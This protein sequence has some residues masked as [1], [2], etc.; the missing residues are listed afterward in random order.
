MSLQHVESCR[1]SGPDSISVLKGESRRAR[2]TQFVQLKTNT[3][4]QQRCSA[5]REWKTGAIPSW[6]YTK[7][8]TLEKSYAF[9][10][11]RRKRSK[12]NYCWC[13]KVKAHILALMCAQKRREKLT[14]KKQHYCSFGCAPGMA[15]GAVLSPIG[16]WQLHGHKQ[17]QCDTQT[18]VLCN[19]TSQRGAIHALHWSCTD[20]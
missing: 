6:E 19:R 18:L 1:N 8:G 15:S 9:L 5:L 4:S 2:A 16:P 11:S 14:Q 12:C 7:T 20:T 13:R 3:H 10:S 17:K